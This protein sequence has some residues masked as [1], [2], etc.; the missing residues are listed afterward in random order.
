VR[1][2]QIPKER[3]LKVA[4][5][6]EGK[7]AAELWAALSLLTVFD[8]GATSYYSHRGYFRE[9]PSKFLWRGPHFSRCPCRLTMPWVTIETGL[10]T[11]DGHEEKLREY[12]CDYPGCPNVATPM[13]GVA[14]QQ[15]G[16]V[17]EL[18]LL[19]VPRRDRAT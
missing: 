2:K 10:T 16:P 14:D 17:A 4:G 18:Y 15:I 8:T 6:P 19:T 7:P 11:P 5:S 3:S 13:L 1:Q 12:L 9:A